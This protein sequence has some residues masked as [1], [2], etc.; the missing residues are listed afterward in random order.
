M[1]VTV[2]SDIVNDIILVIVSRA[3]NETSTSTSRRK[4]ITAE[5]K[6]ELA[7][8]FNRCNFPSNQTLSRHNSHGHEEN[9]LEKVK[10]MQKAKQ[11]VWVINR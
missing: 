6:L 5:A 10:V 2:I 8:Y 9:E 7:D 3:K 1:L 11:F 4:N